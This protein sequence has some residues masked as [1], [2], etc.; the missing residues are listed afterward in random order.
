M[1]DMKPGR[2]WTFAF[3]MAATLFGAN[4]CSP[5]APA[6][7]LEAVVQGNIAFA[8]DLYQ[9]EKGKAPNLF[10]SP[11]SLSTA[12]A[13]TY[14]GAR[15]RTAE[16]MARTLHFEPASAIVH[17]AFADL[18]SRFDQIEKQQRVSL[19]VANLLWSQ[20]GYP[21]APD[22]LE[23][24]QKCYHVEPRQVDFVGQAEAIRQEINSWVER[25][26]HDK[27]RE[28]L[29]PG[30]ID[31]MTRLVLC[32]A[33]YFKGDWAAKFDPKATRPEPFFVNSNQTV[34]VPLM[35]RRLKLRCHAVDDFTLFALPYVGNDLA[36]VVMLPDDREG[37]PAVEHRLSAAVLQG[38]LKALN[39]VPEAE[40]AVWLPKLKLNCR[41]D[42]AQDLSGMGM[43]SAFA[44]TADFSGINGKRD[45]FISGVVH[46]AYVDVNEEGTEAAAAT[47]VT[48]SLTSVVRPMALRVDHPFLFFIVEQQTGSILFIG[49]VTDPA[50]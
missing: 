6:P 49:R 9:R 15:G 36:M 25:K 32:N 28:L 44:A 31:A 42:L 50:Q 13:M 40:A 24:N 47:G 3:G 21:F 26:T 8:L 4:T 17:Q 12:L 2:R 35:S 48:V 34:T 29:K 38:W 14:A 1:F 27:I 22:F 19:S 41:L 46:Q 33:I 37:L 18:Y 11:Y 39:A 5:D 20:R 10:F 43:P 23:L 45:L 7:S 16:E 30:Q